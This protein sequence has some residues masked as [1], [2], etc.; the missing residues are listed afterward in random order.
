VFMKLW[1]PNRLTVL[2]V[3][4]FICS[5]NSTQKAP[6]VARMDG[7]GIDVTNDFFSVLYRIAILLMNY[8]E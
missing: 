5:D 8:S 2:I 6:W 3:A 7:Y 1:D 4:T